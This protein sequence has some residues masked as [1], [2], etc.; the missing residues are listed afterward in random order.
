MTTIV[1]GGL[2]FIGAHVVRAFAQ[3]G[4]PVVA[5]SYESTRVPSFLQPCVGAGG[6]PLERCK[7]ELSYAKVSYQGRGR[8]ERGG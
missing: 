7:P 2:G 8:R 3:A 6:A 5:T 1:T 4:E